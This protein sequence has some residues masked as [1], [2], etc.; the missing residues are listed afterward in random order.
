MA[1]KN[2]PSRTHGPRGGLPVKLKGRPGKPKAEEPATAELFPPSELPLDILKQPLPDPLPRPSKR[3]LGVHLSTSGGVSTAI[4]R[5]VRIGANTLQ[6]FSSSPRQWRGQTIA[7]EEAARFRELCERNKIG[8][9]VIHANYLINCCSLQLHF[10]A[11]SVTALRGE[12]E[13]AVLLGADYLVLHPGSWRGLT[14]EEGLTAAAESIEAAFEGIPW[15]DSN[16]TLLIENTA[17]SEF[18][19]G[20]TFEQVGELIERLRRHAPVGA[21]LDTCHTHVAGYDIVSD[22]GYKETMALVDTTI[23]TDN[24]RVWHMNDAKAQRGSKLD[25]HQQIGRGTIGLAPFARLM[26]DKRFAHCAF[27]AETPVDEPGDE[28]RNLDALKALVK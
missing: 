19:L 7:P 26:N 8:P 24:V 27:V 28:R 22:A 15:R 10:R 5:A 3:K 13:R 2:L 20:G 6:I 21:C 1:A 18:S 12:L 14:R 25:R 23:G 9:V 16:F 4:E 11:Q 17:G